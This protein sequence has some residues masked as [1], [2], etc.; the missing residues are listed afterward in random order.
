MFRRFLYLNF[1]LSYVIG[2]WFRRRFTRGGVLALT[3]LAGSAM[4]GIDTNQT[5]A[6]Q[7]FTLLLS[8]LGVAFGATVFFRPRIAADRVLPRFAS[9]GERLVYGVVL[10]NRGKKSERGLSLTDELGDPRPTFAEFAGTSEPG[11]EK[12]NPFDRVMGYH[13]WLWLVNRN[14]G[15]VTRELSLPDLPPEAE[16]EVRVAMTPLRRG[17][18][19]FSGL[20]IAR[21][22]PFGLYRAF[23]AVALRQSMLILPKRYPL[24]P[25]R[26]PGT[27]RYQH[28]GVS[29]ACSVGDSEEFVSLR[30]YRPGDPLRRIHWRS[31]ARTGKPVVKEYQD[32]F[33]VRHAL[34]LDTFLGTGH[35]QVFEEAVSVAASFVC[36]L[37]S[38]ESLLDLLFV[39]AQAHCFTSGRGLGHTQRML[40][41]LASVQAC[42]GTPFSA[43]PPLVLEHAPRLSGCICVLLDWDEQR[44][45]F[46][47]RLRRLGVPLLALIVRE[48][49]D[50]RALRPGPMEDRPGH[51]IGLEVGSVAEGLREHLGKLGQDAIDTR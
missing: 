16:V 10:R 41:V 17:R 2:R 32:E 13:R 19:H 18:V 48:A 46:V 24:P 37:Q 33:F 23:A 7:G 45:D 25:I 40:E 47:A 3:G 26:L 29:L 51:L 27:R 31:W 22:D 38:Q 28:G 36:T 50:G 11:E 8:L 49:G 44:R 15:A 9:V 14:R 12:R 39:G 42:T 1:R 21:P 30:E 5:V 6:Y 43:L 20:T 4:V 35:Q 34:V